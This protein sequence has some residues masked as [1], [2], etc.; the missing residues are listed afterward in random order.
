MLHRSAVWNGSK[1]K[2]M[3]NE[4]NMDTLSILLSIS[5]HK[6]YTLII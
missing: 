1:K 2:E 4:K 3:Q 6:H 5:L